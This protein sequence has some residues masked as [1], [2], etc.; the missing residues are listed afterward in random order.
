MAAPTA[1]QELTAP[2]SPSATC[3]V[4]FIQHRTQK[5]TLGEAGGAGRAP[6]CEYLRAPRP[7][8]RGGGDAVSRSG[9]AAAV[10]RPPP[11]RAPAAGATAT[12][13]T[14]RSCARS[15]AVTRPPA[16]QWRCGRSAARDGAAA[17]AACP[18]AEPPSGRQV[19]TGRDRARV[20]ERLDAERHLLV[21]EDPAAGD[22]AHPGEHVD[23]GGQ[24]QVGGRR[25]VQRRL[26]VRLLGSARVHAALG[27]QAVEVADVAHGRGHDGVLRR[28][29]GEVAALEVHDARDEADEDGRAREGRLDGA[30]GGERLG[31]ADD[32]RAGH[33]DRRGGAAHG[34]GDEAD[35]DA[36]LGEDQAGLQRAL[37]VAERRDGAE[38]GADRRLGA[39]LL[40]RAAHRQ[41][42]LHRHPASSGSTTVTVCTCLP[43]LAI[44]R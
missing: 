31:D 19:D 11:G 41:R 39:Q 42:H 27:R 40:L 43:V 28:A 35:R 15:T 24:R 30:H 2:H 4:G 26:P 44:A 12:A 37:V 3:R 23:A 13:S 1:C 9:R 34:H 17:G 10:P 8:R 25:V 36:G 20:R 38:Q 33:R 22:H 14:M 32:E 18:P 21:A 16:V 29:A 5:T 6:S 7:R